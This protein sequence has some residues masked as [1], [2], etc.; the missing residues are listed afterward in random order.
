MDEDKQEENNKSNKASEVLV[1]KEEDT[2]LD[3]M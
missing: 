1:V 2:S 3:E